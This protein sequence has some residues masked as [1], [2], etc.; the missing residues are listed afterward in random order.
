[1]STN[2]ETADHVVVGPVSELPAG[3]HKIIQI[4]NIEVGVYN[5]DGKFYALP[6]LC[7]HQAGPLCEGP[8]GGE[9]ICNASTV[10]RFKWHRD[11]E[12]LTCPWHGLEFDLTTG[13]CLA[14]KRFRVRQFPVEVVDGDIRVG[15]RPISR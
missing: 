15:T 3:S 10:W 9:M 4:R 6:N 8:V 7:P 13:N 11:G 5:V 1:M 12:I 2:T 14:P